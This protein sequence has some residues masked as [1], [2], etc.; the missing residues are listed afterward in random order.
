LLISRRAKADLRSWVPSNINRRDTLA[1]IEPA[2][3]YP[4][5]DFRFTV[6]A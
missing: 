2:I 5:F 4:V 3:R 1:R 6:Y